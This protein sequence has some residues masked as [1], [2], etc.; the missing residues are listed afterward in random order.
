MLR[1]LRMGQSP[2]P[3]RYVPELKALGKA[4]VRPQLSQSLDPRGQIFSSVPLEESEAFQITSHSAEGAG[5]GI[6]KLAQT[7]KTDLFVGAAKIRGL[8][9]LSR[10]RWIYSPCQMDFTPM[11]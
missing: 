8:P 4:G 6:V 3:V 2:F 5:N 1:S 11:P 9:P 7:V 10:F